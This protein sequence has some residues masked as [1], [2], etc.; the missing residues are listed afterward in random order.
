MNNQISEL[1]QRIKDYKDQI[2]FKFL[3]S[4]VFIVEVGAMTVSTDETGKIT[5]Q[6]ISYPSQFGANAIDK[7]LMLTFRDGN[8]I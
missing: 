5:T 6:N 3:E 1:N 7:I 4:N 2:E 8:G